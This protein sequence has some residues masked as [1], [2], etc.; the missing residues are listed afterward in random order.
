M[1]Q[2]D[3]FELV[4]CG[5]E[6][7][8]LAQRGHQALDHLL[9]GESLYGVDGGGEAGGEQQRAD[10]SRGFLAGLEV[11]DLGVGRGLPSHRSFA[12]TSRM[13]EIS[14]SLSR[15]SGWRGRNAA[16]R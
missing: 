9:A 11:D 16:G 8:R 13:P 7:G 3:L 2:A 6:L 15:T 4:E 1:Y 12:M 14:V 10:L 5:E